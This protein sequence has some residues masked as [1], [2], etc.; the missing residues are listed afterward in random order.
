ME[1]LIFLVEK[2]DGSVKARTYANGST[3][4][5]YMEGNDATSPTAMMESILITATIDAKQKR[6]VMT[7]NILNAFV[8][9]MLMRRIKSRV[10][11]LL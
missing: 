6:D 4:Y 8:Q 11:T 10:S 1:R 3:Q 9:L 5:A 7:A 2:H